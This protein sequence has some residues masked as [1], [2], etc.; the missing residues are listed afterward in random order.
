MNVEGEDTGNQVELFANM[1]E[2]M[3]AMQRFREEVL[4]YGNVVSMPEPD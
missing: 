2:A 1:S 4:S 3:R